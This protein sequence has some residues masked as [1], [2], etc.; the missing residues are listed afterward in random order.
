MRA[1]AARTT[2]FVLAVACLLAAPNSLAASA[3]R[4][5]NRQPLISLSAVVK[6]FARSGLS[7]VNPEAG[8]MDTVPTLT[9]ATNSY[10]FT[11]GVTI[12]PTTAQAKRS[13]EGDETPWHEAGYAVALTRNVIIAVVP[14]GAKLDRKAAKPFPMPATVAASIA[15]LT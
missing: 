8:F 11:L 9:L 13:F 1:R 15:R 2:P 5:T 4:S 6:A 14:R 7:L 3:A 10:P 12:Y